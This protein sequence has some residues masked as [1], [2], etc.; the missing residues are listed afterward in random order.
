MVCPLIENPIVYPYLFFK[1]CRYSNTAVH[2]RHWKECSEAKG[3]TNLTAKSSK[4]TNIVTTATQ[5]AT[6]SASHNKQQQKQHAQHTTKDD[7]DSRRTATEVM[8]TNEPCIPLNVWVEHII[9]FLDRRSQNNLFSTS[10]EFHES[11]PLLKSLRWP[12][13]TDLDV[14]SF[15]STLAFSPDG[16]YLAIGDANDGT[17][18]ILDC[19]NGSRT[20]FQSMRH[21]LGVTCL[22]FSLDSETLASVRWDGRSVRLWNVK[23]RMENHALQGHS[24]TVWL[25]M[26]SPVDPL[27]LASAG[28]DG[29]IRLW[30]TDGSCIKTLRDEI[31]QCQVNAFDFSPDGKRLIAVVETM[32]HVGRILFWDDL[33]ETTNILAPCRKLM[34][35]HERR[36]TSIRFSPDGHYFVTGSWDSTIRIWNATTQTCE[37]ILRMRDEVHSIAF[38]P[39]GKILAAGCCDRSVVFWNMET[40]T[41]EGVPL[42]VLSHFH[43]T[44]WCSIR[45]GADCTLATSGGTKADAV[46]L[47]NPLEHDWN[48][49]EDEGEYKPLI[50][51]WG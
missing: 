24:D 6:S 11:C 1:P 20:L 12:Y 13:R 28:R 19:A 33:E 39:N 29:S 42:W 47:W 7:E 2:L 23:E 21:S 34:H 49:D 18:Q 41:K 26:F 31:M 46:R 50:E 17:I 44:S 14:T 51:M 27:V 16:K 32:D 37:G 5:R 35:N 3:R 15:V 30:K 9:P 48:M 36:C 10:K 40:A 8:S 22:S 38:T 4:T 43:T 25:V 45:F